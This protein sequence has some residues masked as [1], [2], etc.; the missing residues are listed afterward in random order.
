VR[1]EETTG[2]ATIIELNLK[3]AGERDSEVLL[4]GEGHA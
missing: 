1:L 3:L 4:Q 2:W